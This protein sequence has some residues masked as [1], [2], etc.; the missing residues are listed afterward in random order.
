MCCGTMKN[1]KDDLSKMP[2]LILG[3]ILIAIGMV[4]IKNT[5]LGLFPWGVLHE[6]IAKKTPLSLGQVTQ[7]V[8][9]LI[10]AASLFIKIY[11]GIGTI[12]NILL[13]G[14]FVDI[15]DALIGNFDFIL[16]VRLLLLGV[17]IGITSLGRAL[18]IQCRLGKGPRDGLF[19][20]M[21]KFTGINVKYTKPFTEL[22]ALLIGFLLGGIVGIGTLIMFLFSGLFVNWFFILFKYDPK[23][24]VQRTLFD[25]FKK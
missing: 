24:A 2:V 6:G 25:Y 11:P 15:A 3:F 7:V 19:I 20:G 23:T 17:G 8:G 1:F 13:V 10:L 5:N 14:V 21:T 12:L 9:L 22:I 18:Y 16:I 4:V